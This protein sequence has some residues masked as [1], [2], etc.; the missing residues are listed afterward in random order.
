[1]IDSLKED[2]VSEIHY[3]DSCQEIHVPHWMQIP[4]MLTGVGIIYGKK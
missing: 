3:A 2:A 4:G 1:M